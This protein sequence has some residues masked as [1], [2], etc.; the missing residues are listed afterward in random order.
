MLSLYLR[1]VLF[2]A[3]TWLVP[4]TFAVAFGVLLVTWL[5]SIVLRLKER[6]EDREASGR[7]DWT[8]RLGAHGGGQWR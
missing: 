7:E 4:A 3:Q 1:P 8:R 5:R 6:R 2:N